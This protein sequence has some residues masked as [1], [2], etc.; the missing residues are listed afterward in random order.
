LDGV[1]QVDGKNLAADSRRSAQV[2]NK[3]II[4][5]DLRPSAAELFLF[6]IPLG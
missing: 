2:E 1:Q 6:S 3:K 4:R 5:V